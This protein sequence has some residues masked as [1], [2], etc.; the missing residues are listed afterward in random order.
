MMPPSF[1]IPLRPTLIFPGSPP[2]PAKI[3]FV[4]RPK[5]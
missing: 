4:E 1:V 3:V 5:P 2:L